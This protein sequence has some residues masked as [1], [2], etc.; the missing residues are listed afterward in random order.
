MPI[1]AIEA[2]QHEVGVL[3][4]LGL[5][6]LDDRPERGEPGEGLA[7]MAPFLVRC[8]ARLENRKIVEAYDCVAVTLDWG[9]IECALRAMHELRV[10]ELQHPLAHSGR[11]GAMTAKLCYATS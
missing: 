5:G 2:G 6:G 10:G 11:S 8:R 3:V 1:R 4:G 7:V 9:V